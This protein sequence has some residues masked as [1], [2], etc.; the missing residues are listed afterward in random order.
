MKL[1]I[2]GK[3]QALSTIAI[4]GIFALALPLT[5][6]SQNDD[7]APA[8]AAINNLKQLP[9]AVSQVQIV[10]QATFFGP[11]EISGSCGYDRQWYCFGQPC[12]TF[13]WWWKFP[14]YTWFK[15]SLAANYN[16]V[17]AV[18]G[19]FDNRF[20]PI[21]NW[22]V[23]TLP[24]FSQQFDQESSKMNAAGQVVMNPQSSPAAVAQ[25]KTD[26]LQSLDRINAGLQ[27]GIEQLNS[28]ISSMSNFNSQLN[29]SLQRV[30]NLRSTLD[31][32]IAADSSSMNQKLAEYPCG[33][34]DARN[35]YNGIKNTVTSQFQ[36]VQNAAQSYGVV[37]NQT[38]QSV[39]LIL[40]TVLNFQTRYQGI[41]QALKNAQISP[42]GAIQ[43]LRIT[44]AAAAW[45]DFANY[46][47][48]QMR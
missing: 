39:S 13:N 7:F 9:S 34:D 5:A 18:A 26:I 43:Q 1:H 40:G 31:Q 42:A 45:R 24:Q 30:N 20:S 25:A 15:D 44:V 46:A 4:Q 29:Q 3:W 23:T 6:W 8:K 21:K 11:F 38:D 16:Q 32:V 33:S 41:S 19:Q 12:R 27:P 37:S 14:N 10:V 47:S 48:Q 22:M 35:K 17:S 36:N 2:A 28:G